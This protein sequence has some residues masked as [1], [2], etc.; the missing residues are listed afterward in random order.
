MKNL[1]LLLLVSCSSGTYLLEEKKILPYEENN[2]TTKLNLE[3]KTLKIVKVD[4]IRENRSY[5]FA[6]TGVKYQKTPVVLISTLESFLISNLKDALETRNLNY[7]EDNPEVSINIDVKEFFVEELIEKFKP[8]RAK[9]RVELVVKIDEDNKS[10]SGNYWTE[11]VSAGDL[12]DGTERL[13]PTLAS[14][15][16]QISEKIVNDQKFVSM[17]RKIGDE[18]E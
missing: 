10:W 13:A 18:N 7:V 3:T 11:Y 4:D 8:E 9:C 5:G 14:C 1:V 16:N 12:R 6:Y 15:L 2:T 17:I